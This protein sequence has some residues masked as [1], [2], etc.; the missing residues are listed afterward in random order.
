MRQ[1]IVVASFVFASA[2]CEGVRGPQGPQGLKGDKG[3]TGEPGAPDTPEEVLAKIKQVDGAGSGLDADTLDSAELS[4]LTDR[5]VALETKV[6]EVDALAERIQT[7]ET[8]LAATQEELEAR[9]AEVLYAFDGDGRLLGRVQDVEQDRIVFFDQTIGWPVEVYFE[10][11]VEHGNPAPVQYFQ[12]ETCTSRAEA[13]E[14]ERASKLV[15]YLD[16]STG[17]ILI[18][19]PIEPDFGFIDA[20]KSIAG[21]DGEC[22]VVGQQITFQP[23][24]SWRTINPFTPG[25]TIGPLTE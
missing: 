23:Y 15:G 10:P 25:V 19:D 4:A 12:D 2:G 5:L 11:I 18:P 20:A 22:E 24:T 3:D 8:Q 13:L 21:A 7:L 14:I 9:K 6:T 16:Q 17:V 1:L